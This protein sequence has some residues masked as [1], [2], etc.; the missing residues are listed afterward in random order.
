LTP[1]VRI[2]LYAICVALVHGCEPTAPE[3]AAMSLAPA[4]AAE[5]RPSH[6]EIGCGDIDRGIRYLMAAQNEDGGWGEPVSMPAI[7]A[8]V[9][10]AVVQHEAYD[11]S[12][13]RVAAG[14]ASLLDAAQP[15]GGI[16]DP[17]VGQANYTTS[18]AVM[19]LVAAGNPRYA[20]T[21]D[22][23]AKYL[24]GIQIVAG[25]LTPSGEPVTPSHPFFGGTSYGS[26]GRPDLS[27]LSFTVD[28][29]HEAGVPKSHPF[30]AN[31]V[32]FIARTQNRGERN[33]QPWAQV[34][35]DGGFV[36]A[37][38]R[39]GDVE[40]ESKADVQIV[41]GRRGLRSYGS[42]TYSGF[43]SLLHAEVSRD[44]PRVRAAFRWIRRH[45]RLDSNPNMPHVQSQQGLYY[46]YHVFAKA[47]RAWGEVEISD[48]RGVRHNWREEL[49]EVLHDRQRDDG[50][51]VN[52]EPR[53]YEHMPI[54]VTAYSVLALQECLK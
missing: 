13:P 36:Y 52:P 6:I 1:Q 43:K 45:W 54:L 7:T 31:A 17:R 2:L 9:L 24:T 8:L 34:V 46:Y 51:W 44:D 42:M 19:A 21:I 18:V 47:L 48:S 39:G 3:P 38:R 30:F 49:I 50:S 32:V 23:A 27:N 22:K 41:G 4:P 53:W 37:P 10:K 28:A 40:G 16:Y 33:D 15:D 12:H 5:L 11:E 29:L 14:F 26:H 20:P 25:S 35:N